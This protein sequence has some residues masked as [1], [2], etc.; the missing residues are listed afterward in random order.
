MTAACGDREGQ[1]GAHAAD[2][3]TGRHNTRA[4]QRP[5]V[6]AQAQPGGQ[7]AEPAHHRAG[8]HARR[9]QHQVAAAGRHRMQEQRRRA[10]D[11]EHRGGQGPRIQRVLAD[12]ADDH[13][14]E[15]CVDQVHGDVV[16]AVS[17]P[18]GPRARRRPTGGSP[19]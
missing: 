6:S 19:G 10:A 8:Q 16:H 7:A 4:A 17:L 5:A 2:P 12:L 18:P 13:Q 1:P 11:R 14:D 9:R 15:D 3:H